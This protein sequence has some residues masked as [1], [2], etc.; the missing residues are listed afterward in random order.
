M[1]STEA[2][3]VLNHVYTIHWRARDIGYG[4]EEDVAEVVYRGLFDTWG[5]YEWQPLDGSPT[6]YLFVDEVLSI[7]EETKERVLA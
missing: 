2:Y 4:I 6:L 3:P 5:K 1:R 7:A